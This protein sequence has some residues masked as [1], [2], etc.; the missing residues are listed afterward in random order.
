MLG[1]IRQEEMGG[2]IKLVDAG[3]H[4]LHS[5]QNIVRMI[6]SKRMKEMGI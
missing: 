6:K 2:C 1:S 4:N 3:L 5:L